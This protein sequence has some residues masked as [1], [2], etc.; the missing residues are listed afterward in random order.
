LLF[1]PCAREELDTLL[2]GG[3]H[4]GGRKWVHLSKTITS[5]ANAGAVHN[6]RPAIVEIDTIQMIASGNTIFHAGTTV[7]LTE[8]VDPVFCAQVPYDDTEYSLMLEE[9][10]E[11]E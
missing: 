5:A 4:P 7:Y 2:E 11:E 8:K 9:W 3:I 6:F 10:G 1:Y